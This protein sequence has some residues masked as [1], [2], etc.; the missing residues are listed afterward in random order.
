MGEGGERSEASREEEE[1]EEEE[2]EE[3]EEAPNNFEDCFLSFFFAL[4]LSFPVFFFA[5]P[6]EPSRVEETLEGER[7]RK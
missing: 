7:E 6:P 5:S 2:V 4:S 3:K 1:E